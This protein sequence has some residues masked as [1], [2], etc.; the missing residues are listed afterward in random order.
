VEFAEYV[1]GHRLAL[2]RFAVVLT[3]DMTLA[4]DVVADT[5]G[6]AFEKWALVQE[7]TNIHAY[8]RRMVVNEY[9]G[10]RR[11]MNV[12]LRSRTELVDLPD[13]RSDHSSE[14]AD[15]DQ[16]TAELRLLP[17][18]QRAALVLRYYEGLTFAEIAELL[19]TGENAVRSNISRALTRLRVQM[20][21]EPAGPAPGRPSSTLEISS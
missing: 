21:D 5:L 1:A 13:P 4:D 16:L 6:R 18:K 9:L 20:A 11:R 7:S 3:G 12:H 14:L 10:W 2:Y 15:R 17:V 8:V 19:G